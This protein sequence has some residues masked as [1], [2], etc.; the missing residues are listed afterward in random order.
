MRRKSGTL[1]LPMLDGVVGEA[2]QGKARHG[3]TEARRHGGTK[4]RSLRGGGLEG[5]RYGG[6][7]GLWGQECHLGGPGGLVVAFLILLWGVTVRQ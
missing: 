3:G 7:K 1:V 4:G 2:D 6:G 5:R